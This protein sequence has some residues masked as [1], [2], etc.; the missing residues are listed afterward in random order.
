MDNLP[1]FLNHG[2][3]RSQGPYV[4]LFGSTLRQNKFC[5]IDSLPNF[6]THVAP[7]ELRCKPIIR[8]YLWKFF[9][10]IGCFFDVSWVNT[11]KKIPEIC[12][13]ILEVSNRAPGENLFS[14][15]QLIFPHQQSSNFLTLV[16]IFYL[17]GSL[18]GL[19][20]FI[21]CFLLTLP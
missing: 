7:R 13:L 3:L 1:N 16:Y 8:Q 20:D 19:P 17:I 21:S 10:S 2:F 6:F 11:F 4:R 5:L 9:F 12:T 14:N 18:R 15:P